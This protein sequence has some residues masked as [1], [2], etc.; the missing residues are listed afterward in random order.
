MSFADVIAKDRGQ[1]S[2]VRIGI[3]ISVSPLT[4]Q[5]QNTVLTNVGALNGAALA[6]GSTVALLGQSAVSA[7][8][9]SWLALGSVSSAAVFLTRF[10]TSVTRVTPQTL[11]DA[12]FT[13]VVWDTEVADFGGLITVPSSSV[14]IPA[15]LGGAWSIS[16]TIFAAAAPTV[17]GFIAIR[18]NGAEATRFL[19]ADNIVSATLVLPLVPGD[20]VSVDVY[21]DGA[22]ASTMTGSL[23]V[24]RVAL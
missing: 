12:A 13:P 11:P 4:V 10:G 20:V 15:G 6:V 17:L 18:I 21:R 5:V 3:V 24:Y 2:T 19:F 8:G 22:A 14:T 23:H 16:T 1:P 9:S 7:D